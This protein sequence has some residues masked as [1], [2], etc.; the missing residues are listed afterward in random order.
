MLS[1][2]NTIKMSGSESKLPK[3]MI[4]EY[5]DIVDSRTGKKYT[6]P[7]N[8]NSVAATDFSVIIASN[9]PGSPTPS[10]DTGLR[11]F[12][13][14]FKNTACVKSSITYVDGIRG[15][16]YYRGNSI[17]E[18][19]DNNDY[20]EVLHLLIWGHLPSPDEKAS[21]RQALSAAMGAPKSVVDAIQAFPRDSMT[22]PMII[23]GLA[24]YAAL[25]EGSFKTHNS[26]AAYYLGNL[27]AV[28]AAIIRSLSAL[29]TTV[30]LVYCHKRNRDFTKPQKD[31]SFI[32]NLLLMMGVSD[33]HT[34]R[35]LQSLW[36]LY[37]DHEMT[38]STSAFLHSASNLTDPV[39]C[40]IAGVVSAYGPLH[41]GAIDLAYQDYRRIGSTENVP[42]FIASVKDHKQRLFGYGHRVYKT[43]DPRSS[44]ILGMLHKTIEET[45]Q[46]ES[47]FLQIALEIDRVA[48]SDSYFVSRKIKANADLFGSLLYTALGFETDIII[49]L[50]CVSRIGGA[51]AHWREA[52]QQTPVLW[53]P[54]QLYV[55][56]LPDVRE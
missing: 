30:A 43:V 49:A 42:A 18:L 26:S 55:G 45:H 51:M 20:E 24:A 52:M 39:S 10:G 44:A 19:F 16:I 28:D 23:A 13:Q 48:N 40:M 25:D 56:P 1:E 47:P 21:L 29:A 7:I 5:L 14:G 22:S 38:N 15:R 6:V 33:E 4:D 50:A 53:R 11:I 35:C 32:G 3:R 17:L 2:R 37:A 46:Q 54:Q 34:E 31:G 27:K 8:N 9:D 12:D 41:G 36:V